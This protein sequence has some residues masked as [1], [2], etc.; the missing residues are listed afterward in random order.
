[1]ARVVSVVP[2]ALCLLMA[3]AALAGGEPG[4][5]I[6]QP[7]ERRVLD[8]DAMRQIVREVRAADAAIQDYTMIMMKRERFGDELQPPQKL[9]I[10]WA[11]PQ[12]VY[13]RYFYPNPGREAIFDRSRSGASLVVHTGSFPDLTLELDPYGDLATAGS[14]YPIPDVSL[15]TFARILSLNVSLLAE[16][17]DGRVEVAEET[18]WGRPV[19]HL[20]LTMPAGGREETLRPGETLWDLARRLKRDMYEILHHNAARGWDEADDP[21]PGDQVYVPTYYGSAAEVWLDA[22]LKLPLKA[23]FFDHQG[24]LYEEFEHHQLKVNQGIRPGDF[25]SSNPAYNF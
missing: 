14:H 19:L 24:R 7:L 1:L 15:H 20:W 23:R 9:F 25:D 8:A 2:G 11:R 4:D 21:D 10:R 5:S 22:E 12:R 13:L 6:A 18:L 3:A 16:R 17:G